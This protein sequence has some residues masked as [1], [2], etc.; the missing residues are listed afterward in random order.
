MQIRSQK[1]RVHRVISKYHHGTSV[2][3]ETK[4]IA[5][6]VCVVIVACAG[7]YGCLVA[8]CGF[9]FPFSSVVSESMQHDNYR[10]EIGVIDTGDIVVVQDPSKSE[11]VSYVK[12][13][14][15]GKETFGMYGSVIIYN[16]DVTQNPVIHRAIIW[17]DYD[18]SA[19]AEGKSGW[20]SSE[21]IG[22]KEEWHSDGSGW[23][24]LRG[25]LVIHVGDK[26][27]NV[28][29]D[30]L[31]K[32]S[33]FLTM[34]DNPVTNGNFDQ[35]S[36]IINHPIGMEDIRSIPILELPWFGIVKLVLNGNTH[37]S[38]VPNSLPTLAMTVVMIFSILFIIDALFIT[39]YANKA[40][41]KLMNLEKWRR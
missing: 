3:R 11:I 2:D 25:E 36:G 38:H 22:Y 15:T 6:T 31:Q 34:G 37:V 14:Q 39:K 28:D 29:L 33:G 24:D 8:T 16:R 13:S 7:C 21:L 26:I 5:M 20:S 32:K 9:M 40:G 27:A 41:I 35:S 19:A 23:N 18:A 4:K 1:D 30:T 12:G 10:S 17:L